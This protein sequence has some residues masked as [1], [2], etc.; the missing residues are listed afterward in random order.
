MLTAIHVAEE[1]CFPVAHWQVVLTIPKRLRLHTRFDRKL[2][3]KLAACAWTYV[4]A[5]AVRLL[6]RE[7]VVPGDPDSW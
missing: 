6:G 1:V 7:D 3:G 4:K 2:L 5:E